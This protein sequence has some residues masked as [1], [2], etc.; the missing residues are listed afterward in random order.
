MPMTIAK[1]SCELS[2]GGK[3]VVVGVIIVAFVHCVPFVRWYPSAQRDAHP[4]HTIGPLNVDGAHGRHAA[5]RRD[6]FGHPVE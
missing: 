5:G 4:D 6:P 1:I 2:G 3:G